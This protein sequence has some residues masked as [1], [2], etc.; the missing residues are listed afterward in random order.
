MISLKKLKSNTTI[1][2][3]VGEI[4]NKLAMFFFLPF[5][6]FYMS[7]AEFGAA[8]LII[9][10]IQ[11]MQGVVSFGLPISL[12]KFYNDYP[13]KKPEIN[14][15]I[16]SLF[17]SINLILILTIFCLKSS[18]LLN[19]FSIGLYKI[20]DIV[21]LI[22]MA[23]VFS[24]SI[25][26]VLQKYQ[27]IYKPKFFVIIN[28][29]SR[30]STIILLIASVFIFKIDIT[31]ITL[32]YLILF[33]G[34]FFTA[35]SF[36][37][38]LKGTLFKINY[39]MLFRFVIIGFPIFLN[40]ILSYILQMNGRI[41]LEDKV[42][43]EAVGSFT[44]VFSISQMVFLTIAVYNRVFLPKFY[45]VLS[46]KIGV[47]K[48]TNN[49]LIFSSSIIGYLAIIFLPIGYYI[50]GFYN[51]PVYE[52]YISYLP[53]LMISFIPYNLYL[54]ST[55]YLAYKEKTYI[56][57]IVS[58]IVGFVSIFTNIYLIE[59][60]SIFGL[61]FSQAL[62]QIIFAFSISFFVINK[63]EGIRLNYL[64]YL[65]G[66][67]LPFVILIFLGFL[68]SNSL[69]NFWVFSALFSII[70]LFFKFKKNNFKLVI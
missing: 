59:N 20:K 52:S 21:M 23:I 28:T 40:G 68:K 62:F 10:F 33:S 22:F 38:L 36:Y 27:A 60:Y 43:I 26:L 31:A 67:F 16:I 69:I 8:G 17:T 55:N 34:V 64:N 9:P 47:N 57:L 30:L 37:D 18:K 11:T 56:T 13:S 53:F 48:F 6:A 15:N 5:A 7:V 66:V 63:A 42:N 46:L 39:K 65:K 70:I 54:I 3:T 35:Y 49:N 4:A 61:F 12:L 32:V 14:F 1:I 24:S 51:N 58:M 50:T 29:S 44:F 19:D 2:Y 45:S 41:I 25:Q